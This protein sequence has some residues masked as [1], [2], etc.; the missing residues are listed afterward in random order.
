MKHFFHAET[1]GMNATS[2]ES[3]EGSK[4][5]TPNV[6]SGRAGYWF[7]TLYLAVLFM[8]IIDLGFKIFFF[9]LRD[10]VQPGRAKKPDEFR[11]EV[12][13]FTPF[14]IFLI[15]SILWAFFKD[16]YNCVPTK[17]RRSAK[18]EPVG[19]TNYASLTKSKMTGQRLAIRAITRHL[20]PRAAPRKYCQ[21]TYPFL[22]LASLVAWLL[23]IDVGAKAIVVQMDRGK[24]D[25]ID[26]NYKR[27]CI[28][29]KEI[30]SS[31]AN[32]D[33][34]E[35]CLERSVRR[36][37]NEADAIYIKP[38]KYFVITETE[39]FTTVEKFTAKNERDGVDFEIGRFQYFLL[40]PDQRQEFQ[41]LVRKN[42]A[43]A[44]A[45]VNGEV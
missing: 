30:A 5:F 34:G 6:F 45:I 9:L 37:F 43:T 35:D 12:L 39:K 42:V 21:T 8:I 7:R 40:P 22:L 2:D 31:T 25:D 36:F 14:T 44:Q 26:K 32:A 27:M 29:I 13:A 17:V 4:T 38:K 1:E 33:L 11:N 3:E 24:K 10:F 19:S 41:E 15:C 16:A 18:Y 23:K 28:P 20:A